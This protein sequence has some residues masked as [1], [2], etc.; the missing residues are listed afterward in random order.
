[1]PGTLLRPLESCLEFDIYPE[2][3]GSSWEASKS[4][5]RIL[6]RLERNVLFLFFR[7]TFL[8]LT[9]LQM[10]PIPSPP[11]HCPPHSVP[12]F[13]GLLH[14]V[15]CVHE[16]CVYACVFLGHLFYF[17]KRNVLIRPEHRARL[18]LSRSW[19]QPKVTSVT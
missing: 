10:Y 17:H 4:K 18:R 15:V 5:M 12:T 9:L 11:R 14:I 19:K 6:S 1:M 16:L 13:S 2:P 3:M 8:L 7:R